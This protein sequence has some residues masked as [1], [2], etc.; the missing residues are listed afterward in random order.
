MSIKEMKAK[1]AKEK[2]ER[3]KHPEK[4]YENRPMFEDDA[5]YQSDSSCCIIL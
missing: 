5:S 3:L 1:E 4:D 2:E